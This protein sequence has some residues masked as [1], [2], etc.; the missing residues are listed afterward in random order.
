MQ[1]AAFPGEEI[2]DRPLPEESVPVLIRLLGWALERV[3][4][5]FA[6]IMYMGV[7]LQVTLFRPVA[8]REVV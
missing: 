6:A 8:E 7:W 4:L 1:Q 5:L 3:V 2:S